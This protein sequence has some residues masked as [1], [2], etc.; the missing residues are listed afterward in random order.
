MAKSKI[1]IVEDEDSL[2]EVLQREGYE[3][4]IA[5]EGREGLRKAQGRIRKHWC[6][7]RE[8]Q[9]WGKWPQNASHWR[10]GR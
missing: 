6:R 3:D 4:V 9:R 7:K 10:E 5:K 8:W 1:L 2:V